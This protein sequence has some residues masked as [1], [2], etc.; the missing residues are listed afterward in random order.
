MI[1]NYE[2][3]RKYEG[4]IINGIRNGPGKLTYS[5]GAYYQGDFKDGLMNG[6]GRLFYGEGK[7]AYE[8]DWVADQF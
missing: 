2:D 3:G 7:V 5:D 8:G 1:E 4:I 6:Q